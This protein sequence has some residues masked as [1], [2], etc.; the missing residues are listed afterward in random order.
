M[1]PNIDIH[2]VAISGIVLI[3]AIVCEKLIRIPNKF[4]PLI[5]VRLFA[6]AMSEKVLIQK[7][8]SDKQL[9]ISGAMSIFVMLLPILIFLL[10]FIWFAEYSWFFEG[11]FLFF[12]IQFSSIQNT[13]SK[14]GGLLKANKKALARNILS[15]IVLRQ[16]ESLSSMGIVKAAIETY[17]LRF[18]YQFITTLFW[19]L[20]LG[21]VAAFVYRCCYEIS[22]VWNIKNIKYKHF[23]RPASKLS[24]YLQW[25]PVRISMLLFT[26][27][28][29]LTGSIK[30]LRKLSG[31][32]STHS[33][34][35]A[36]HAGAL[37][38]QLGGPAFYDNRK[39]RLPKVGTETA[40]ELGK[41]N[42]L[43][44]LLTQYKVILFTFISICYCGMYF[45]LK[46]MY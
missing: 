12:A 25:I 21:G 6:K 23:G 32:V 4:H 26:G 37:D 44:T 19:F 18:Q 45:L 30:A 3:M 17:I 29:G 24:Y 33:M 35:L 13:V 28:L 8:R 14:V 31:S 42:K 5:L 38:M 10:T 36:V 20:I 1:D 16:V 7:G 15:P 39:V 22:Q 41:I 46:D 34:I 43:L 27:T 40:P 2:P 11:L 9:R